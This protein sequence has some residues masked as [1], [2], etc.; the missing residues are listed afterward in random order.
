M[1]FFYYESGKLCMENSMFFSFVIRFDVVS[2]IKCSNGIRYFLFYG[3]EVIMEY[4]CCLV[5]CGF[6]VV[7]VFDINC[8][9]LVFFFDRCWCNILYWYD[10][11]LSCVFS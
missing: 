2:F 10:L 1:L 3:I 6:F 5:Y 7:D 4:E 9:V 11:F 8:N